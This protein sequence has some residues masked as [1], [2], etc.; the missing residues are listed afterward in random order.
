MSL[1]DLSDVL[2]RITGGGPSP[3][4]HIFWWKNNFS[5][6][7]SQPTNPVAGTFVSLFGLVGNPTPISSSATPP[8]TSTICDNT[9]T[10][11]LYIAP[12]VSGKNY[13]LG[14][15]G[16]S[17][18]VSMLIYYDRL[19]HI[20]GLSGTV[21]TP[22]TVSSSIN[23][24]TGSACIG[25]R[26]YVDI[27]SAVGTTVVKYNV[28]YI[29]QDGNTAVSPSASIGGTGWRENA[30]LLPVPFAQGDTGVTAV[31]S[32]I[33]SGTTTTAGNFGVMIGRPLL[34]IGLGIV[35]CISLRDTLFGTDPIP[36][37][38]PNACIAQMAIASANTIPIYFGSIH[39]V[40][41]P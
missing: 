7:G 27:I 25:N 20:A 39:V 4:Q 21:T 16:M 14:A 19:C 31:N 18:N 26:M 23:R 6:V 37:I 3:A 33:L 41:A 5:S 22:Q 9:T 28:T 12:P 30:S 35:D 17:S 11:S 15:T 2:N 13:L 38:E 36:T 8:L 10:G 32:I 29:N 24:Y 34:Q 1:V 40:E